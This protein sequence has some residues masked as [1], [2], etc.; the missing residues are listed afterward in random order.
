MARCVGIH[1]AS[2]RLLKITRGIELGILLSGLIVLNLQ[3]LSTMHLLACS[4]LLLL[5]VFKRPLRYHKAWF[6]ALLGI[7]LP[8]VL[9]QSEIKE[10]ALWLWSAQLSLLSAIYLYWNQGRLWLRAWMWV[11]LWTSYFA[12]APQDPLPWLLIAGMGLILPGIALKNTLARIFIWALTLL[13][14]SYLSK[15]QGPRFAF[16]PYTSNSLG[17]QENWRLGEFDRDE[18]GEEASQNVLLSQN[19]DPLYLAGARYNRFDGKNW[20]LV[21]EQSSAPR[22]GQRLEHALYDLAQHHK[23]YCQ[24]F[25]WVFP[26]LHEA[27]VFIPL[28]STEILHASDSLL[29]QAGISPKVLQSSNSKPYAWCMEGP[30]S[31]QSTNA[32]DLS[33]DTMML[34]A[35]KQWWQ[36]HPTHASTPTELANAVQAE[37]AKGKYL[38]RPGLNPKEPMQDFLKQP[39]GFC[40]HYATAAA[41]LLRYQ[42]IPTRVVRG[43][44]GGTP[45]GNGSRIYKGADA[46]AWVEWYDLKS[47]AWQ[48]LDPTPQALPQRKLKAKDQIRA[49]WEAL[50]FWWQN[51]TWRIRVEDWNTQIQ[52]VQPWFEKHWFANVCGLLL[53]ALALHFLRRKWQKQSDLHPAAK[54][55]ITAEKILSKLGKVRSPEISVG[56][57]ILE[58]KSV[59]S[60]NAKFSQALELLEL[61]QKE[62]WQRPQ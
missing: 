5:G 20:L 59:H 47:Q 50:V 31:I 43:F 13:L 16:N 8:Y 41:L 24:N 55:L 30:P 42:Q 39:R 25:S 60:P 18:L 62:R 23:V 14:A 57:W 3:A 17:Y 58:L 33:L 34:P 28:Q 40:E 35:L 26:I 49:R 27:R 46:H 32:S 12:L 1:M 53:L 52:K 2:L 4:V 51:G 37:L 10:Q 6:Y 15:L 29:I 48:S 61:Y 22:I 7:S 54:H 9:F 19:P 36:S 44:A 56:E 38:L 11:G 45:I 21:K